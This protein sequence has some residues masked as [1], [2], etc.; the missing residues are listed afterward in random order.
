MGAQ[1]RPVS[2]G[3]SSGF[4]RSPGEED[5]LVPV[6]ALSEGSEALRVSAQAHLQLA[7]NSVQGKIHPGSQ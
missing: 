7:G 4:S 3:R 6:A 5:F 1:T 2:S